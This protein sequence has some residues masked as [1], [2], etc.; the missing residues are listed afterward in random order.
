MSMSMSQM[1]QM[2]HESDDPDEPDDTDEA[3]DPQSRTK[4]VGTLELYHVSPI[5]PNQ[6]WKISRFFPKKR[7]KITRLSTLKVG[8]GENLLRVPTLLSGIV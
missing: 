5:P 8:G 4:L 7:E 2:R 6:C 1:S 3:D